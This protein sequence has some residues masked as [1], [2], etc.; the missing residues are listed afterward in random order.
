MRPVNIASKKAYAMENRLKMHH[1]P[2][3]SRHP[4]PIAD[5]GDS[6]NIDF[7]P[8]ARYTSTDDSSV[9]WARGNA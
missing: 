8:I 9:K 1:Q 6:L 7:V 3:Y 4:N 2:P 5:F